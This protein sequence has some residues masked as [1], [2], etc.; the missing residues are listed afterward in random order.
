MAAPMALLTTAAGLIVAI[1]VVMLHSYLERKT[2]RL[3]DE[4]EDALTAVF[5]G[6]L[7]GNTSGAVNVS[8]PAANPLNAR[9][10]RRGHAA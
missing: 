6:P 2:D 5:T 10:E 8:E 3:V 7:V 1:P 4:M 9:Y